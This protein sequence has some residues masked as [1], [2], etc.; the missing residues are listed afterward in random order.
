[1]QS[2][3]P[4]LRALLRVPWGC[5]GAGVLRDRPSGTQFPLQFPLGAPSWA[6]LLRPGRLR[7]CVLVA[8]LP[9]PPPDRYLSG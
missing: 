9:R 2:C 7:T 1:M 4:R 6:P 3:Q 8:G 5:G